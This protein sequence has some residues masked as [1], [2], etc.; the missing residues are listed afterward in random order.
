MLAALYS[1]TFVGTFDKRKGSVTQASCPYHLLVVEVSATAV[2]V[3]HRCIPSNMNTTNLA[4]GGK[5]M[6]A[7]LLDYEGRISRCVVHRFTRSASVRT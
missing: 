5:R 4:R 1:M 6:Q 2:S 7:R 3:V